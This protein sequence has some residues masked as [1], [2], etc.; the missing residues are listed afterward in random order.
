MII[1]TKYGRI[2]PSEVVTVRVGSKKRSIQPPPPR[3][4]NVL[5][6]ETKNAIER[7]DANADTDWKEYALGCVFRVARSRRE[8]TSADV[9]A[10]MYGNVKGAPKTYDN[11][12]MGPVML[13]AAKRG[14]IIST[15]RYSVD[16]ERSWCHNQ[17]RRIWKSQIAK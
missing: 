4:S 5:F 3:F 12:A 2:I 13:R 15:D 8:F 16:Y 1:Y 17:P 14:W 9:Y 10:E 11:R 6:A 7:V